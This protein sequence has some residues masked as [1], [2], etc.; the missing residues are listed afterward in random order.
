MCG[1][2][3]NLDMTEYDNPYQPENQK[4]NAT[5]YHFF[6]TCTPSDVLPRDIIVL[7]PHIGPLDHLP[8][9]FN[10]SGTLLSFQ[11]ALASISS[12]C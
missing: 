10:D 6:N 11:T 1:E 8:P 5:R 12:V 4:S 7:F 3:P 2:I 9:F